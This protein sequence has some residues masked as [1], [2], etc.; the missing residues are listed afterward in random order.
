[1]PLPTYDGAFAVPSQ[2]GAK[3][4]SFPLQNQAEYWACEVAREMLIAATAYQQ[5]LQSQSSFTNFIFPSQG[6]F[7]GVVSFGLTVTDNVATAPDG[8]LTASTLME[9]S[10]NST[11]EL[12]IGQSGASAFLNAPTT[13][14]FILKPNGRNFIR[15]RVNDS[16]SVTHDAVFNLATVAFISG[17][18]GATGTVSL[19]PD[20]SVRCAV[21][22][23]PAAGAGGCLLILQ[24]D[25]TTTSY[26]GN[27]A[28]GVIAWGAQCEAAAVAGVYV[29]TAGA[30]VSVTVGP[31]DC[32]NIDSPTQ[33]PGDPLAF[34]TVDGTPNTSALK[35]GIADWV[36][37]YTRIP[38]SQT[39]PVSYLFTQP[40]YPLVQGLGMPTTATGYV[41]P[42]GM[43]QYVGS[44][45]P[46]DA[47]YLVISAYFPPVVG[48]A[49]PINYG[50]WNGY[51]DVGLRF[52]LL[53][54]S[55]AGVTV[56][57][58]GN[59]YNVGDI[60]IASFSG[61]GAGGAAAGY[62]ITATGAP[63]IG[64]V[65]TQAFS[66]P[67]GSSDGNVVSQALPNSQIIRRR[68][69]PTLGTG[70]VL[71]VNGNRLE[72]YYLV[73]YSPGISSVASIPNQNPFSIP[74][75]MAAIA[76]SALYFNAQSD[77]VAYWKGAIL[78]QKYIQILT[79]N[80]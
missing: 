75:Y 19:L 13:F 53:S 4:V 50:L 71:N 62:R 63:T 2:T 80:A 20:G 40:N 46:V 68:I 73:G 72:N 58:S 49:T 64:M 65:Q 35:Q 32:Q 42:N 76:A 77:A 8:T 45:V 37:T 14:S 25:A 31:V 67:F 54:S 43:F 11:H 61:F 56:A 16:A 23:T 33:Q 51:Y 48:Y 44:N 10:A 39:V 30:I 36:R 15:L 22:C 74:S 47:N 38:R 21:T 24:P 34:L 29:P 70:A 3:Q 28:L 12:V 78:V 57:A 9:T 6:F 18:N 1:M 59:S 79:A 5:V 7:A 60:V 66:A 17:T 41:V 69:R 55:T 26:A 52:T 27:P